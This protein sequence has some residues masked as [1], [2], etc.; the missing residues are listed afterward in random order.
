MECMEVR[1]EPA[2]R[3]CNPR[4]LVS[5]VRVSICRDSGSSV[6]SQCM[7]TRKPRSAAIS[8][9]ART[10]VAPSSIVRSMRDAADDLDASV[11]RALQVRCRAGR[12][13]VAVL[14][15]GHELKIEVGRDF[16]PDFEERVDGEKPVVAD[17]DVAADRKQPL[18]YRKVAIA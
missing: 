1:C 18:R 16:A 5:K 6:S 4:R 8:H 2:T 10:E 7:S 9:W 11:Q 15:E 3:P 14:G 17:V 13:V 12:A